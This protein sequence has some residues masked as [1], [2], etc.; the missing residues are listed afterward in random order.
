VFDSGLFDD[1][2]AGL[3]ATNAEGRV[4]VGGPGAPGAPGA[5]GVPFTAEVV[6]RFGGGAE[7]CR[8][9]GRRCSSSRGSTA[10]ACSAD[11][12]ARSPLPG[13]GAGAGQVGVLGAIV[14]QL[15]RIAGELWQDLAPV[16]S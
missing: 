11:P 1:L 15:A 8:P 2:F 7:P 16:T 4:V 5:P 13:S 10:P 14:E 3:V 6:H 9:P 12:A